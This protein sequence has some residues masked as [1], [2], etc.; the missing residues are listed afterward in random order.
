MHS[1]QQQP[2][3]IKTC[4]ESKRNYD[5]HAD[6]GMFWFKL[7]PNILTCTRRETTLQPSMELEDALLDHAAELPCDAAA[8]EEGTN[9]HEETPQLF[10]ILFKI[11]GNHETNL[12][13]HVVREPILRAFTRIQQNHKDPNSIPDRFGY[14]ASSFP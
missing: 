1:E 4:N 7:Q 10:W 8:V 11:W 12:S 5:G 14:S 13:F 6:P 2:E 9:G 3:M